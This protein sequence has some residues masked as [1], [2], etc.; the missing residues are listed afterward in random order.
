MPLY[1]YETKSG[2]V[3]EF[4][5]VAERDKFP[6]GAVRRLMPVRFNVAQGFFVDTG[7]DGRKDFVKGMSQMESTLG[8]VAFDKEFRK[9]GADP[10]HIR[11]VWKRPAHSKVGEKIHTIA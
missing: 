8:T 11:E 1:D 9:R 7:M 5:S 6:D 10:K 2:V 3:T 4:R